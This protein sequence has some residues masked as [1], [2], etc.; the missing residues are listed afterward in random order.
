MRYSLGVR[1]VG[2]GR[3]KVASKVLVDVFSKLVD[4]LLA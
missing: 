3:K 1:F 2:I 4:S